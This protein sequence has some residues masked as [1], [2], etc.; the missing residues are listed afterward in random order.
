M[1]AGKTSLDFL[2]F[3]TVAKELLY[4]EGYDMKISGANLLKSLRF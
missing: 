3:L 2:L 4:L 1:F